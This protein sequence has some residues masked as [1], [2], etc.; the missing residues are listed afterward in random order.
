MTLRRFVGCCVIADG[1]SGELCAAAAGGAADF[2][3][4]PAVSGWSAVDVPTGDVIYIGSALGGKLGSR[5]LRH[6]TRTTDRRTRF[7][8]NSRCDCA[9]AVFKPHHPNTKNGTGIDYL[10]DHP[11][12]VLVDVLILQTPQRLEPA[13]AAL[14]NADA[15]TF[16]CTSSGRQ[17]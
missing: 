8:R 7:G 2:G 9:D 6:A 13:I 5:L 15:N 3:G 12:V 16:D 14:L 4:F 10:L 17:R 11:A 1:A